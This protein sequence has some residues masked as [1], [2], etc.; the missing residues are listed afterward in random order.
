MDI[1]DAALRRRRRREDA[2][3]IVR[4]WLRRHVMGWTWTMVIG[5]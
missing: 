1:A 5:M 2:V 3:D 4:R